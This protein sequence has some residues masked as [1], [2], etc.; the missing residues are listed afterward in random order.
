MAANRP[1]S[2]IPPTG[3][4][5]CGVGAVGGNG[6]GGAG[7]VCQ[8]G[9]TCDP[10]SQTC[11]SVLCAGVICGDTGA[12]DPIDGV[13]KCGGTAC[14]KNEICDELSSTC[15]SPEGICATK[16]PCPA[17]LYCDPDK[18]GACEC[19]K[20]GPACG[21]TQVCNLDGGCIDDPCFGVSCTATGAACYNG[22]CRCGGAAGVE[23][24]LPSESCSPVDNSCG[25]TASCAIT[26]CSVSNTI[27]SP[28]DTLCH[29][30]TTNGPTCANNEVCTLYIA[31]G[32]PLAPFEDA[33]GASV[34]GVCKNGDP[35]KNVLCPPFETCDENNGTG[36]AS[37]AGRPIRMSRAPSAR[38]MSRAWIPSTAVTRAACS[39]VSPSTRRLVSP[40]TVTRILGSSLPNGCYFFQASKAAVC[41]AST[42]ADAGLGASCHITTDCQLG[43]TCATYPADG[44]AVL[45]ASNLR[46]LLR[47]L[48]AGRSDLDATSESR[49]RDSDSL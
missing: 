21:P 31:D 19:Y 28:L 40:P 10:D 24:S 5:L 36:S 6:D 9:T 18:G 13:C 20:G 41:A 23:C 2:A 30:G 48:P 46:F 3:L 32:G 43:L 34:Y 17:N 1:P 39:T 49:W 7:V 22:I 12:C 37:A 35:C 4:C 45:V 15:V 14:A 47:R 26:P 42:S 27:C 29:C 33:G 44:G 11:V 38:R 25:P 8:A 16:P